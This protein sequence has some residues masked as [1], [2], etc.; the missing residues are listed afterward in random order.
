M[1]A[2]LI[3]ILFACA[4]LVPF[5]AFILYPLGARLLFRAE[6]IRPQPPTIGGDALPPVDI[7]ISAYNE[8][9]VL[10]ARI[11]NLLSQDYP[12]E[13][14]RIIIHT[15]GSTDASD[16]IVSRY[17]SRGVVHLKS[18]R[19]HGK[20]AALNKALQAVTAPI[21][22]YSDANTTFSANAVRLLARHFTNPQTGCV[23]GRLVY[24]N[25]AKKTAAAEEI[26][27]WNWDARMKALEGRSGRLLGANGAIFALRSTLAV[28]LPPGQSNDMVLPIIAI[29]RGFRV[30]FEPAALAC[31]PPARNLGQEFRRKRRIIARGLAGVFF[32]IRFAFM[33]PAA[34][35]VSLTRRLG[36]LLHLAAKK[37][38]RYM[39]FPCLASI[40]LGG[41]LVPFTTLRLAAAAL[42]MILLSGLLSI[43]VRSFEPRLPDVSYFMMM[44]LAACAG[45]LDF[46]LGR[47]VSRWQS[48][49]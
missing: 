18:N 10:D 29:L 5:I 30:E 46:V 49:R 43:P 23:C 44:G 40:M 9:D 1:T 3:H 6:S 4:A 16:S 32:S 34:R 48:Q 12:R 17:A 33:D 38:C 2:I 36:V 45:F 39:A 19:N 14:L 27:Y 21:L 20:T 22:V 24:S 11:E 47:N 15:D 7:I 25:P 35:R 26:R 37:L 31:E 28:P 42:W 8:D 41:L 13:L